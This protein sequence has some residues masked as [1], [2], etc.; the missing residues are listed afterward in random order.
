[1]SQPQKT[2]IEN[3]QEKQT[4]L[5]MQ[6]SQGKDIVEQ[7]EK[8]LTAVVFAIQQLNEYIRVQEEAQKAADAAN[9]GDAEVPGPAPTGDPKIP[10]RRK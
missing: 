9:A 1:M 8:E 2:Q 3:L 6:R 10:A 5:I 7:S 4:Q